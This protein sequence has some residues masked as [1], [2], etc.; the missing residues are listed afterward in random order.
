MF[1][2]TCNVYYNL[3]SS[4]VVTFENLLGT[5]VPFAVVGLTVILYDV[6]FLRPVKFVL[7]WTD[8]GTETDWNAALSSS[9]L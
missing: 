3:P 5:P 1:K 2:P 9:V 8:A 6:N 4:S 7:S